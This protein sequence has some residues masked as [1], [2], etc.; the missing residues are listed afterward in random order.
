[1]GKFAIVTGG[2]TAGHIHPAIAIAK[3]LTAEGFEVLYIGSDGADCLD[4]RLVEKNGIPFEGLDIVTPLL[5]VCLRTAVSIVS[6]LRATRRCKKLMKRKR[7]DLVVGTG[8][9]VSIPVLNAA[10]R[11][12]IRTA[13]HEQNV[14]PGI[15][16]RRLSK[17]VDRVFLTFGETLKYLNCSADKVAVSGIP[18]VSAPVYPTVEAFAQ[19]IGNGLKILAVGGSLGSIFLNDTV[20]RAAKMIEAHGLPVRIELSCGYAHY[21]ELKREASDVLQIVP[22]INDMPRA[23]YESDLMI[24]RA[25]SS[26]V[27]EGIAFQVPAIVVP[28]PNVAGDHQRPNA[29]YW[30]STGSAICIR[31]ADLNAELLYEKIAEMERDRSI[32]IRMK[33]SAA[34]LDPPDAVRVIMD[35]LRDLCE[36][37]SK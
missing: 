5:K 30:A 19:R 16:N 33:A 11:L 23:L 21:E 2:G 13:I 3:A 28:S 7:P 22:Y 37:Y 20:I 24:C 10:L 35:G 15:T 17:R 12:G 27:F 9:F 6:I 31:E 36:E 32:L 4:R 26:T 14:Y 25:G 8:G 1:M 29:E 34:R 18:L